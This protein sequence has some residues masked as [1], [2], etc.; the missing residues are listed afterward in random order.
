MC[1]VFYVHSI[2]KKIWSHKPKEN[3]SGRFG[4]QFDPSF[5]PKANLNDSKHHDAQGIGKGGALW[6]AHVMT[7]C[8]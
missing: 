1:Y 3:S 5:S 4:L 6:P 7:L 8:L 2:C